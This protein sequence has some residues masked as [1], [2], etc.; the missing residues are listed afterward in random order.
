MKKN[1]LLRNLFFL[2]IGFFILKWVYG[3]FEG[4]EAI[5]IIRDNFDKFYILV[6]AH[7]PTLFFDSLTWYILISKKKLSFLWALTI[8][9]IAQTS[10]KFLPTGNITGEF[11][12]IYLGFKKGLSTYESTSTVLTDLVLATFSLFFIALISYLILVLNDFSLFDLNN[13]Y[14]M[15]FSLGFIFLG[16]LFFYFI[17]SKR[18]LK[19]LIKR[20]KNSDILKIDKKKIFTIL[21]VDY[22]LYQLSKNKSKLLK[23]FI[24]RLLGWVAGAFEIYIFLYIIGVEIT[25][26]DV[27][28][29]E[30]FSGIIR[31]L[32]FFIPAGIGV[33]ELAF[34]IIGGYVGLSSSISFSIALGRRIREILVGLPGIIVWYLIFSKK[35]GSG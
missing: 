10:G 14:Y 9:W 2:L 13:S 26:L 35:K 3:V 16:C 21:K 23:A 19:S 28:L 5:K 11:V 32:V 34:V 7:L 18:F 33:Q 31:A 4:E 30:A 24:T 27:I 17:I 29:I 1:R 25:I 8:T 15:Y 22:S 20:F 6:V 12:R